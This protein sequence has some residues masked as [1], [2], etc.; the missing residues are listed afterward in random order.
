MRFERVFETGHLPDDNLV[1]PRESL[2]VWGA[3]L[4][5]KVSSLCIYLPVRTSI[6]LSTDFQNGGDCG[7][8][9][10]FSVCLLSFISNNYR[11]SRVNYGKS[12]RYIIGH[13][14]LHNGKGYKLTIRPCQS[15]I[16]LH[17]YCMAVVKN[18]GGYVVYSKNGSNS[19]L[20]AK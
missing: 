17:I 7:L 18:L 12:A 4:F 3:R 14:T 8:Q 1:A 10:R 9:K 2:A 13:P 6:M 16:A 5:N 15:G 20:V 11:G 19:H